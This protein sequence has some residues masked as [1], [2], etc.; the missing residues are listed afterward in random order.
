MFPT[1][2]PPSRMKEMI[3]YQMKTSLE[4]VK[5]LQELEEEERA[6]EQQQAEILAALEERVQQ[7]STMLQQFHLEIQRVKPKADDLLEASLILKKDEEKLEKVLK[8]GEQNLQA[9]KVQNQQLQAQICRAEQKKKQQQ[10]LVHDWMFSR[11]KKTP[12]IR[13]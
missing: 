6:F 12:S 8:D 5:E 4:N 13:V 3:A 9:K 7:A 10:D 2:L 1:P 11:N